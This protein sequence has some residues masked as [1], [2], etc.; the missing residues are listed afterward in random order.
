MKNQNYLLNIEL[1]ANTTQNDFNSM[2]LR[3]QFDSTIQNDL[4]KLSN[5]R[6]IF[7]YLNDKF[8][9]TSNASFNTLMWLKSSNLI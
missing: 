6:A 8:K 1:P 9:P 7:D 2:K 5:D 3:I 4:K